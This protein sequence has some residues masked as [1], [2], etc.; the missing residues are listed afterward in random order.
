MRGTLQFH[1]I[2][3]AVADRDVVPLYADIRE[4]TGRP[5]INLLFQTLAAEPG[6][7]AWAWQL[8]RPGYVG[9]VI[10]QAGAALDPG[11]ALLPPF[12]RGE[13][14]KAGVEEPALA[15]IRTILA[16]YNA[17]NR[18][19]AIVVALL[20]AGLVRRVKLSAPAEAPQRAPIPP[21]TLPPLIDPAVMSA[22]LSG[23]VTELSGAVLRDGA[24]I[25]PGIYRHLAH[26]PGFVALIASA[27]APWFENGV[28]VRRIAALHDQAA[29]AAS[30]L[31][32]DDEHGQHQPETLRE[33][34]SAII[35]RFREMVAAMLVTGLL[36]DTTLP[37]ETP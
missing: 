15:T 25:V 6:A 20:K 3:E 1:E 27:L 4:V 13:L 36:L 22:E 34:V 33:S 8:V 18:A 30:V 10:E 26:W 7:L 32:E 29:R 5:A 11:A 16:H 35:T 37:P 21:Y 14:A 12:D 24:A 19:T 28:I 17:S 2:S 9:G 23:T 31:I